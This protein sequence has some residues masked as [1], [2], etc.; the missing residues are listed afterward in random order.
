[1]ADRLVQQHARPARADQYGHFARRRSHRRKIGQRLVQRLVDAAVPGF[2]QE[3]IVIEP[4]P[5]DPERAGFAAAIVF[6][7]D[8]HVEPHER[9][10]VMRDKAVGAHHLD[11][12]PRA[13]ER[14][15]DLHHAGIAG[16]RGG[17]DLFEQAHLGFER[18]AIE[19]R[20]IG[21]EMAVVVAR[22]RRRLALGRIEQLERFAGAGNRGGRNLVGMGKAGHFARN[23]AQAKAGVAR[24]V[25]GLQPPI[26]KAK[27]FTGHELQEQLAIIACTQR[28]AHQALRV[29]GGEQAG[30]IEQ[31]AGVGRKR[32]PAD[33][34]TRMAAGQ[35]RHAGAPQWVRRNRLALVQ[36]ACVAPVSAGPPLS[37]K[38]LSQ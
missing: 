36:A 32:H 34:G 3:Q 29:I 24:I 10:H 5:T 15:R 30:A 27:A 17:I 8:R 2:R 7:H 22:W 21:I 12:R 23:A 14:G 4:P 16:A 26:I 35:R 37:T 20:G 11:H 9:A 19:R 33:I 28:A 13:G 25:C 18:H 31:R 38:R 1:M 6:D